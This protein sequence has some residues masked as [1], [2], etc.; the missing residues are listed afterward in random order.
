MDME[1]GEKDETGDRI[2]DAG[3]ELF[4]RRGYE[5]TGIQEIAAAAGI[6]KP[7]LYYHFGSKQGLLEAIVRVFG[8]KYL[9]TL[10]EAALYRHDLVMNLRALL[11][12]T[13]SFAGANPRFFRLLTSLFSAAPETVPYAAGK[14][15][16]A[17]LTGV[18]TELFAAASADH[19]NMKNRQFIYGEAFFALL[20]N[21]AILSL[22]GNLT[23]H[24]P[25][26]I[27]IIHQFMHGI[28]S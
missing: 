5:G 21:N 15:L 14:D 18:L 23:I 26:L 3:L 2:L 10:T 17:A 28:F 11:R 24:E 7:S 13:L 8:R 6:T 25:L 4:S 22:N 16:R 1:T 19:G 9:D 20:Q 27:Q 12:N